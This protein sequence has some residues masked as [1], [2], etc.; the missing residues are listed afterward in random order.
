V[1]CRAAVIGQQ[2]GQYQRL[3]VFPDLRQGG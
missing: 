1:L 2:R 3:P